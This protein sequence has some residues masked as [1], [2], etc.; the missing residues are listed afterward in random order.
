MIGGG[1]RGNKCLKLLFCLVVAFSFMS[2]VVNGRE[3]ENLSV[4]SFWKKSKILFLGNF[5]VRV[6]EGKS[7]NVLLLNRDAFLC[8]VD[9]GF[10]KNKEKCSMKI[11]L[12]ELA[13]RKKVLKG[14]IHI[15][16]DGKGYIR[17]ILL[18]E[19]PR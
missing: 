16:Y 15:F 9:D 11:N 18:W 3:F 17:E 8:V 12:N 14:R 10:L 13:K 6:I 5:R 1:S 19:T 7:S 4:N 2:S